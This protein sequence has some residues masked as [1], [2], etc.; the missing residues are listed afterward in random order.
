MLYT[1]K[2]TICYIPY[3]L[4][5]EVFCHI[6]MFYHFYQISKNC[7]KVVHLWNKIWIVLCNFMGVGLIYIAIRST[8]FHRGMQSSTSHNT[9]GHIAATWLQPYISA[10]VPTVWHYAV[11]T[12]MWS[13]VFALMWSTSMCLVFRWWASCDANTCISGEARTH[14]FWCLQE[15]WSTAW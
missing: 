6:L 2:Y 13:P 4:Q 11:L 14:Q 7:T 8:T 12:V 9:V 15:T 5:D 10:L 3:A 1:I